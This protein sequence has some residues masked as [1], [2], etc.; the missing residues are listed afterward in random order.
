VTIFTSRDV[1]TRGMGPLLEEAV[2]IASDGVDALYVTFDIDC[3]DQAYAPGT[4]ASLPG[5][6]TPWQAYDALFRLGADPRVKGFDLVEVDP[7]RDVHDITARL[8]TK[9]ILTLLAG[10]AT[11]QGHGGNQ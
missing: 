7:S 6:V 8:A 9:L 11:R 10:Y 2:A 4:G 1:A 3:F 5:G